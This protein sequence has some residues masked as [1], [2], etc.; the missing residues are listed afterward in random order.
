M[1]RANTIGIWCRVHK[2]TSLVCTAFLLMLCLTGLPLIFHHEIDELLGDAVSAPEMPA[3]TPK[4]ALDEIV[5]AGMAGR[6]GKVAQYLVWDA[7]APDVIW[8]LVADALDAVENDPVAIDARTAAVLGDRTGQDGVMDFLL[9]LHVDMFA[10]LPGKLFLGAMGLLF[11]VAVVSGVVVYGPFMRRLDFGTVRRGGSRRLKWL[12]LHNLLGVVTLSWALVVG[13]TGV[14]NTWAD[15]VL[16]LWKGDQLAEMV[17]AYRDAPPLRRPGPVGPAIEVAREAAP[18]TVPSFV[19][20]PGTPLTSPHHYAVFMRGETPLTARLVKPVLVDAETG[21]LT[22][23]RDLPWYVTALLV[24]QPLHFGDYGGLPL[25][26][27]WALLDLVTI[28]VLGSGLY[29]WAVR[30]RMPVEARIAALERD[31]RGAAAE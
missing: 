4:A 1:L 11:V 23:T 14:I 31:A 8:L 18:D 2:W 7:D 28:A 24:S 26:I 6:E 20:F 29:L 12:D 3:G 9:S 22:A 17:A 30:R 27:L 13:G 16:A 21:R 10:G 25:K 19:A 15:L 5:T